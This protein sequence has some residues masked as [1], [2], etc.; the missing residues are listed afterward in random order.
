M[1]SFIKKLCAMV[2][3]T[4]L[5]VSSGL[6]GVQVK[7]ATAPSN[8]S[9]AVSAATTAAGGSI[10][11]TVYYNGDTA[12]SIKFQC[13]TTGYPDIYNWYSYGYTGSIPYYA[14]SGLGSF[15]VDATNLA[16]GS[17]TTIN[18]PSSAYG[19]YNVIATVTNASGSATG[20]NDFF[21]SNTSLDTGKPSLTNINVSSKTVGTKKYIEIVATATD[22]YT[23]TGQY[24]SGVSYI[25]VAFENQ[26][27][28]GTWTK[29]IALIKYND[30]FYG[31]LDL[32]TVDV[33]GTYVL[34]YAQIS[35]ESG[36]VATYKK[37]GD[38]LVSNSYDKMFFPENLSQKTF[39]VGEVA[40]KKPAATEAA[41]EVVQPADGNTSPKTSE[42][43]AMLPALAILVSMILGGIS[44]VVVM[45][46]RV[47]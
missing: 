14:Y 34:N 47:R 11:V 8:V 28:P 26:D 2:A 42:N 41:T 12:T 3:A 7:A 40:D 20:S 30:V 16:S 45:A 38:T 6:F 46:K 32:S 35:D 27:E 5:V 23:R 15:T 39:T 25:N 10:N 44:A 31:R 21:V 29:N 13:Y 22:S 4:A 24:S 9:V 18:I 19:D 37:S 33:P 36:N 43:G 1:K 17:T